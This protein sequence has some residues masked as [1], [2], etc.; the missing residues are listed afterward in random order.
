MYNADWWQTGPRST[1]EKPK[2]PAEAEYIIYII[3]IIIFCHEELSNIEAPGV[4][5]ET[6]FKSVPFKIRMARIYELYILRQGSCTRD[7][8]H[9]PNFHFTKKGYVGK[10]LGEEEQR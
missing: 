10:V 9:L 7:T 4:V 6:S 3:I 1:A 5:L 8:D 2:F